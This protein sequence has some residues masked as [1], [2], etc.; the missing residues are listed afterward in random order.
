ML[1]NWAAQNVISEKHEQ[2]HSKISKIGS[3]SRKILISVIKFHI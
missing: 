3:R 2:M 1:K